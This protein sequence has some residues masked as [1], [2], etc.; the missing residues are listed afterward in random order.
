MA[1]SNPVKA[2]VPKATSAN[3]RLAQASRCRLQMMRWINPSVRHAAAVM[4][5]MVTQLI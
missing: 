3:S 5:Q 1:I 4:D 2:A